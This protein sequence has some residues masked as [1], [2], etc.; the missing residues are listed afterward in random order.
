MLSEWTE[1]LGNRV[2][3]EAEGATESPTNHVRPAHPGR[4][5]SALR[6]KSYIA[7]EDI[8]GGGT[9]TDV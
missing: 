5:V 2:R 8:H 3:N 9:D 1:D 7:S 4:S 6:A